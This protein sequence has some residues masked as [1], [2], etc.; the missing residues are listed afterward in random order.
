MLYLSSILF[1]IYLNDLVD[2]LNDRDGNGIILGYDNSDLFKF[3]ALLLFVDNT[4]I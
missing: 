2:S 3:I 1:V 4:V